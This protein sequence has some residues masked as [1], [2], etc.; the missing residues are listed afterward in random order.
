VQSKDVAVQ[1]VPPVKKTKK[2]ATVPTFIFIENKNML[3]V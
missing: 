1:M 3:A 2:R